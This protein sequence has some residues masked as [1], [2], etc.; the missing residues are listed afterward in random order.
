MTLDN[1][2]VKTLYFRDIDIN[3]SKIRDYYQRHIY[4]SDNTI[5]TQTSLSKYKNRIHGNPEMKK[6]N[7]FQP[8]IDMSYT[9][10][11]NN[12]FKVIKDEWFLELHK[13]HITEDMYKDIDKS[14]FISEN[15][16]KD[17]N[18]GVN[19]Y[20]YLFDKQLDNFMLK[21]SEISGKKYKRF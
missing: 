7:D 6:A 9:I 12:G 19:K 4:I 3:L 1:S 2:E 8:I 14:Q 11:N 21:S 5:L 15:L 18:N 13:Y 10:L 20:T 17:K 16:A